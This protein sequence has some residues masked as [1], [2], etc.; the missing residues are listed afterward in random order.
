[1]PASLGFQMATAQGQGAVP[2]FPAACYRAGTQKALSL[3]WGIWKSCKSSQKLQ[4]ACWRVGAQSHKS[5]EEVYMF[6]LIPGQTAGVS[7]SLSRC[8]FC[9]VSAFQEIKKICISYRKKKK[10]LF[11][12]FNWKPLGQKQQWLPPLAYICTQKSVNNC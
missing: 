2:E 1:M 4:A 3:G 12:K 10:F 7:V 5:W 8:R 11:L 6:S 9:I